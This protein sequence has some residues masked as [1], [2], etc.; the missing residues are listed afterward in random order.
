MQFMNYQNFLIAALFGTSSL[1]LAPAAHAADDED[2]ATSSADIIVTA[3]RRSE[4]LQDVPMS[5]A[6]LSTDDLTKAGIASTADLAKASPGITVPQYGA[7][8][9]PSIR[10]VSS[11]GANIGD[12]SNVALYIDGVYQ[13]QQIASLIDLPDVTQV[14]VLKGPQ[15]ALYGQNATGGAILVTT[16]APGF[17]TTGSFSAGY[18]N[19]NSIQLR[20]YLSGPVTDILAVS[21]SG[22]YQDHDGFRK[23]VIT[24]QRDLGLSSKVARGKILLEPSSDVKITLT[25]YYSDRRD[26]AAYAAFAYQDNSIGYALAP[27]APKVTDPSQF[28]TDPNVF[29]R[30]KARGVVINGEFHAGPGTL[31]SITG[32]SYNTT[33]YLADAD[34]SP[35]NFAEASTDHLSASYFSHEMNYLTEK[36]GSL[37]F[38]VGGFF[39][40]GEEVFKYST[41]TLQVPTLPPADHGPYTLALDDYGRIEKRI[42]AFYGDVTLNV[43]DKLT[44]TA[45]GR[46]TIERQRGY[47]APSRTAPTI[48]Y[49]Q[50]PVTFKKFTPRITARYE[51]L[52]DANIYASW[53][54]GFKSGIINTKNFAQ[55]PVNPEVIEAFEAGFKGRIASILSVDIATFH[56]NYKDLQV[57]AYSP[58]DYIQQNAA[59]ARIKG[60]EANASLDVTA[61]LKIGGGFAVLDA[62][63]K[64]F[65]A[66]AVFVPTGF[67]NTQVTMDLSGGQMQRAPK[68]TGN[69]SV[70]YSVGTPIGRV[71]AFGMLYHN[72]GSSF[73]VSNRLR[74]QG[75]TTVDAQ[76]SLEPA[77]IDGLRLTLWGK[78]LGNKAYFA[79]FLNSQFA[80]GVSY[81]EPRTYGLRA[82][83]KF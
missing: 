22:G 9:Q 80:D 50:D 5:V 26:S 23:H 79:S 73:D 25:G 12:S 45:G 59:S 49:W 72:S 2:T 77:G 69:V 74:Q 24:G 43:T 30:T 39:L 68:F 51:V 10:G 37:T 31:T 3:Q 27:T 67:G 46:Y 47:T 16:R 19:Y 21:V 13:P 6:A 35:V 53:G 48:E 7:F 4:R 32:Y 62:K 75:Y 14:E 15:G 83:Y 1:A 55:D 58:P 34:Y 65:P 63:Y 56:Y 81:A 82:E 57:V 36:M 71:G 42:F 76:L 54:K 61:N 28:A 44:V 18:G 17:T 70:D 78:N 8:M 41:F 64:N 29:S 20:G 66:A 38:L 60:V 52:P 11:T 33:R 40:T